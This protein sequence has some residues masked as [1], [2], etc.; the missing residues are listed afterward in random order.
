MKNPSHS[1]SNPVNNSASPTARSGRKV[2]WLIRFWTL[3]NKLILASTIIG[4]IPALLFGFWRYSNYREALL[5]GMNQS[6]RLGA[7]ET[8]AD[9]DAFIEL[10][11]ETVRVEAQLPQIRNLLQ[12]LIALDSDRS[13]K[14]LLREMLQ[15]FKNR[16][17]YIESYALLDTE[18]KN[19]MDTVP[20]NLGQ[21]E[22]GR[23]YFFE[24][25]QLSRPYVSAVEFEPETDQAS[26]YFSSPVYSRTGAV[27]GILRVRY[28]AAVLTSFIDRRIDTGDI[29]QAEVMLLDENRLYLVHSR[30]PN[31][32]YHVAAPLP[33]PEVRQLQLDRRLPSGAPTA[34]VRPNLALIE[35]LE[36]TSDYSPFFTLPIEGAE[37]ELN[38][39][40]AVKLQRQPWYIVLAQP[41]TVLS[42]D[43]NT[44][45]LVTVLAIFIMAG[46]LLV[47]SVSLTNL[48]FSPLGRLVTMAQ[49]MASGALGVHAPTT[50]RDEIG[51][52]ATA[53]NSLAGQLRD[54]ISHS[55]QRFA[56]RTR[57]L[58]NM[59]RSME[60]SNHISH[61][62]TTILNLDELLNFIVNRIQS[63]FNFYYT[64]VYLVEE[65]TGNLVLAEGSGE[66]GRQLKSQNHQ[67]K[68]GQG[69]V[70]T[71]A[72]TNEY[73][74]SNDVNRALNF[75]PNP[76]LPFTSSELAVPLRV[77]GRVV[78]VLDVQSEQANRFAPEDVTMIQAVA[79]QTAVAIDNARLL[80]QTKRALQ[81]VEEL[82]RRLTREVWQEF[83]SEGVSPAYRFLAEPV[84]VVGPAPDAWL[85]PM[86]DAVRD[87]QL[88]KNFIPPNGGPS[89][90]EL[91]VPLILR[92][93]L[94]GVLGVKREKA[95]DWTTEE[96]SAV[97]T[98]AGQ[99]TLALENARLSKEQEKTIVQ[100]KDIDRL[101]SEFLTSMS[102]ELRT[103]LNSIIGFADVLL[104]GIDGDLTDNAMVDVQAIYNSGQHLLALINDILDLSKIEAGK[105][106]LVREPV[107]IA[108]VTEAVLSS[109]SSLIK[110][111]PVRMLVEVEEAM[112]LLYADRLR[113]NQVLL[114]LVSNAVK[115]T[116]KGS[117]TI[118]AEVK[119][120]A[121]GE[122]FISVIDSGWGIPENMLDKI[123][124][125]FRQVDSSSTRKVGGTGLGLAICRQLV[126]MHGGR[127]GVTS[128]MGVGSTFYFT[129]P[130]VQDVTAENKLIEAHEA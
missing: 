48:L 52:L 91:A 14:E 31:L 54:H 47:A 29:Y 124:E 26:L 12:N 50:S 42:A 62:I 20:A 33:S 11:L 15:G 70:G 102:H 129:I 86:Q 23:T 58:E 114:N 121:P 63:E 27:T 106:E 88:I 7:Q 115:F 22:S 53:L 1:S 9:L 37:N 116:E 66:V 73:F 83:V 85:P 2:D 82:N 109:A 10:N 71:V 3:R 45:I 59:I 107:A 117:I 113:L 95:R 75:M 89:R 74:L 98:V 99:V 21:D 128:E 94:I 67:L 90:A 127:I 8:A 18:G 80:S 17:P 6:L 57:A 43:T 40:T 4:I 55:D 110:D 78:G 44:A 79:N 19:V 105:M 61:Q 35:A 72:S 46:G 24:S 30:I 5:D 56:E 64:Q 96:V 28:N 69:I 34:I 103:P 101:K 111:K 38:Q 77:G 97:E 93:E 51:Q 32:V 125:R 81:Q 126:E 60:M 119:D 65:E 112:P 123:F 36:K 87:R 41:Q 76:L 84:S 68:G 100:L 118:R 25:M 92:G 122:V 16:S 13:E 130:L 104:Q 39:G 49:Q 108:D 120:E